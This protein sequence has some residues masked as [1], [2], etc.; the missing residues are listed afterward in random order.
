VEL[1]RLGSCLAYG[2]LDSS[3]APG[4]LAAEALM[5]ALRG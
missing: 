2:Y 5:T 3:A 4:Q 1:G